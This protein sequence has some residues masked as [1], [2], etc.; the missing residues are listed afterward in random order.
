MAVLC[1]VLRSLGVGLLCLAG[2]SAEP[3]GPAARAD[4]SRPCSRCMPNRT[5]STAATRLPESWRSGD[6]LES[7]CRNTVATGD[8][9]IGPEKPHL[10][11]PSRRPPRRPIPTKQPAPN[12][13]WLKTSRPC[14]QSQM[15]DR[16]HLPAHRRW[17]GL[18]GRGASTCS[19]ARSSAGH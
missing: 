18:S 17:L 7:A 3:A 5:A 19:A 1:D 13:A 9:G 15:G 14:A 2:S 8:A 4:S 6:D 16:H 12:Q 10:A 11:K